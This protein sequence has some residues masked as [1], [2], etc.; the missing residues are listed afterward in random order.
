[1]QVLRKCRD[2]GKEALTTTDLEF[3]VKIVKGQAKY[4]RANLC[5]N[6]ANSQLRKDGKYGQI[7][8]NFNL[9]MKTRRIRFKNKRVLMPTIIRTNICSKCGKKY[10]EELEQQT[11]L[12]HIKYDEEHPCDNLMEFCNS[13]HIKIHHTQGDMCIIDRRNKVTYLAHGRGATKW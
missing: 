10:P 3:F 6:C 11:S 13:C 1:M 8:T 2:C 5:K 9:E 4:C 7:R 12:H